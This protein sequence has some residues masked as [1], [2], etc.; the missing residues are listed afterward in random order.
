[1]KLIAYIIRFFQNLFTRRTLT[2]SEMNEVFIEARK[3]VEREFSKTLI[4]PKQISRTANC[5]KIWRNWH[6]GK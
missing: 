4:K 5:R 2:V 6:T 1:M 3:R